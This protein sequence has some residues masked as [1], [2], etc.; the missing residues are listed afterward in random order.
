MSC[1]GR[2]EAILLQKDA[3]LLELARYI[4]LNPVRARMVRKVERWPWSSYR[5]TIGAEVAPD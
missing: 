2:H 3:Y 4:V 5:A 1:K